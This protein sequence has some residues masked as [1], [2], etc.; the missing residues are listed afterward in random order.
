MPNHTEHDNI[1]L[2][3]F[4][5]IYIPIPKNA[6]SS[7]KTSLADA[8]GLLTTD[9]TGKKILSHQVAFPCVPK[10]DILD[11]FPNYFRFAVVRNPNARIYSCFRDKIRARDITNNF[12]LE[13]VYRPFLKYGSFRGGM[14][15]SEFLSLIAEIPD[16]EADRHFR[17][18]S[19]YVRDANGRVIPNYFIKL[20]TF[21]DDVS[22]VFE[23]LG[24][25]KVEIPHL[26][27]TNAQNQWKEA[28]SEDDL[29][30]SKG[31]YAMDFELFGY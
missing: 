3:K 30:T 19:S 6:S 29:K 24:I 11:K 7:I 16:H 28:F 8:L 22:Y 2:E 21:E 1:L 23:R 27:N 9:E 14:P 13:G 31:R 18:Q 20:E 26:V 15:F 10:S 17:S 12:F 4:Q 5:G 25:T